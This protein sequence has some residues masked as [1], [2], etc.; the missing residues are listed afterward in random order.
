MKYLRI[1]TPYGDSYLVNEQGLITQGYHKLDY[2]FSGEWILSGIANVKSPNR[3]S[4][5]LDDLWS[6]DLNKVQWRYKNGNPRYTVI[7]IDHGTTRVW[8]NTRVHGIRY[9]CKVEL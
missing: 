1:V 7:D 5:H 6:M 3:R 9:I 8:G 4:F 2:P